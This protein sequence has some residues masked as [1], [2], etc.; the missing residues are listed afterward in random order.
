MVV[1]IVESARPIL[2]GSV[3]MSQTAPW[4]SI[5]LVHPKSHRGLLRNLREVE[6]GVSWQ[7]PKSQSTQVKTRY[8]TRDAAQQRDKTLV[9]SES[10]ACAPRRDAVMQK[11]LHTCIR[12]QYNVHTTYV[13]TNNA[14]CCESKKRITES[15][16]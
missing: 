9:S 6:H 10:K 14:V 2:K 5:H 15:K 16:A 3:N 7:V 1:Q 13:T 4:R 8:V 12:F 11:V